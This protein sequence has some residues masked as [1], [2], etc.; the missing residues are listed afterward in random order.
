MK[1]VKQ[2]LIIISVSLAGEF[3]AWLIPLPIPAGIYGLVLMFCALKFKLFPLEKVRTTSRFFIDIMPIMFVPPGVA[4]LDNLD[5][6]KAHWLQ[7]VL[8]AFISTFIVMA[9]AGLITQL[10][11]KF[12]KGKSLQGSSKYSKDQHSYMDHS[13]VLL[14]SWH[15]HQDGKL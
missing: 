6:L 12:S 14:P 1:Y 13:K 2:F 11:I 8:T 10:I 4:I 3:L 5:V 9:A 15:P 7:I